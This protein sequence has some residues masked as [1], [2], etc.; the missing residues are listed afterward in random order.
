M[1][2]KTDQ[3][4]AAAPAPAAAPVPDPAP[5]AAR[6]IIKGRVVK[7][8]KAGAPTDGGIQQYNGVLS[9]DNGTSMGF[10]VNDMVIESTTI[11]VEVSADRTKADS[12]VLCK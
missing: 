1:T 4:E 2:G 9:L 11:C 10:T 7:A 3:P 8:E 5:T 6:P 12:L